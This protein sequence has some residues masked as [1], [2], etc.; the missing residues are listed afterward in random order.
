MELQ[1]RTSATREQ[2]WRGGWDGAG[3]P[4]AGEEAR[5]GQGGGEL[6]GGGMPA[7]VH[8][9]GPPLQVPGKRKETG[10]QEWEGGEEVTGLW[11]L[12]RSSGE[13]Q[14][15]GQRGRLQEGPFFRR[16][17]EKGVVGSWEDTWT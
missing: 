2:L 1:D 17:T 15:D 3:R 6:A 11:R 4:P 13:D 12:Q 7:A 10:C 5:P 14:E 9:A 8:G 16:H